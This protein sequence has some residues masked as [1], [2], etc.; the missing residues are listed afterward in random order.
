MGDPDLSIGLN[1]TRTTVPHI[2][3]DAVINGTYP[4]LDFDILLPRNRSNLLFLSAYNLVISLVSRKFADKAV[5]VTTIFVHDGMYVPL[6]DNVVY[7]M[8]T[9]LYKCC[10]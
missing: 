6:Q 4:K 2:R 7:S 3:E 8:C 9:I 5:M 10:I 1:G